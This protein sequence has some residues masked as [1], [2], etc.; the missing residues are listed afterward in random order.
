MSIACPYFP[1]NRFNADI[2]GVTRLTE[3]VDVQIVWH[4]GAALP[5]DPPVRNG[6]RVHYIGWEDV[7]HIEDEHSE[8]DQ[9]D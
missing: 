7:H 4:G 3:P 6:V 9:P 2:Y 8:Q 5:P 1:R